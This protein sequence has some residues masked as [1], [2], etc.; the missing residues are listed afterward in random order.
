MC[1]TEE[2]VKDKN[3]FS[4]EPLISVIIP[5]YNGERF[6]E[7]AIDSALA[8]TYRNIEIIVIDDCS[9]DNSLTYIRDKYA[10]DKRLRLIALNKN[11]GVANARNV[12][13]KEARGEY[14]ALLDN[15]DVWEEDK[16]E[17][18][19]ALA[20]QG[21]DIVYCSYDFIDENGNEIKRPF[22]VPEF[23]DF[24]RMLVSNVISCSTGLFKAEL[25]KEHPFCTEYYHEDYVLWMELLRLPIK[26]VGDPKVLMHYRQVKGS[27]SNKK[28]NA[29]KERWNIYRRALGMNFLSSANAFFRYAINGLRKYL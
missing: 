13:V 27:R 24:N 3:R 10:D 26:A 15:D 1:E 5:N 9:T 28:G 6:A 23:T 12:G 19:M 21:A 16:L 29:A 25:L 11:I 7:C 4:E 22:I 17:R 8:Q 14:I 20:K 2:R 18:Q